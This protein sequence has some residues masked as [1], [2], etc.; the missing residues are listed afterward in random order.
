MV[1]K[2]RLTPVTQ[3]R[4]W[5][6]KENVWNARDEIK[7]EKEV[8][9]AGVSIPGWAI[10]TPRISEVILRTMEKGGKQIINEC[11]LRATESLSIS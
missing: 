8:L 7:E 1:F 5:S 6:G 9:T 11:G 2:G 10:A 4:K 3:S